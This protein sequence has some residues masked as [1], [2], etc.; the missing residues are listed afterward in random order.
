MTL[1][2][3][4]HSIG[5][6]SP[7]VF[8]F[9]QDAKGIKEGFTEEVVRGKDWGSRRRGRKCQQGSDHRKMGLHEPKTGLILTAIGGFSWFF[10]LPFYLLWLIFQIII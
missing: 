2:L 6:S 5:M 10:F 3:N 7:G 8:Q 9:T 1:Y 4:F